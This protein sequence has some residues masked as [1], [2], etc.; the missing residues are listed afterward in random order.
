MQIIAL[1]FLILIAFG[2]A[3]LSLPFATADGKGAGFGM[4]LFTSVSASCVTGFVLQE[5][6]LYW[7]DF[8]HLVILLLFQIGGL[9][10]MKVSLENADL[11]PGSTLTL[12]NIAMQD[13]RLVVNSGKVLTIVCKTDI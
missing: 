7:S 1:G 8:G 11:K 3:L 5:T 6:A 13:A 2:T 9:G 10:V 4:A 12:S